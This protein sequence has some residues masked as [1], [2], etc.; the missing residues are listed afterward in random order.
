MK[1]G[2]AKGLPGE[3]GVGKNRLALQQS[4]PEIRALVSG[5]CLLVQIVGNPIS[6]ATVLGSVTCR[7]RSWVSVAARGSRVAWHRLGWQ[8]KLNK[9]T[10]GD[11]REAAPILQAGRSISEILA[12]IHEVSWKRKI[13]RFL[14]H[15]PLPLWLS[16]SFIRGIEPLKRK[17]RTLLVSSSTRTP[18]KVWAVSVRWAGASVYCRAGAPR[19][20][21][22]SRASP[23]GCTRKL[24]VWAYI[25]VFAELNLSQMPEEI[26]SF[27][28]PV[29]SAP[30]LP[31]QL[32]KLK[33][34]LTCSRQSKLDGAFWC[35]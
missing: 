30:L 24:S 17:N 13:L 26:P 27:F 14:C 7:G 12:Q 11:L 18:E 32:F 28:P 15:S 31:T 20:S 2:G 1:A 23:Q 3:G 35:K 8:G 9:G 29:W 22:C 25:N 6:P 4:E 21:R 19:A 34:K 16:L 5:E 10:A 33:W